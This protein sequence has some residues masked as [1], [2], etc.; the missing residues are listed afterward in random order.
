MQYRL[1]TPAAVAPR[2]ALAG[3]S[4]DG[5]GGKYIVRAM[6]AQHCAGNMQQV[7]A[8]SLDT[9]PIMSSSRNVW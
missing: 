6:P 5:N 9:L 1:S 7:L 8:Q 2:C 4:C 3:P